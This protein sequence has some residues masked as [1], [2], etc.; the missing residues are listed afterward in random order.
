MRDAKGIYLATTL[1][2][3]DTSYCRN[4]SQH[5]ASI[6]LLFNNVISDAEITEYLY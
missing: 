2:I 5:A 4:I 6:C 3:D 1:S